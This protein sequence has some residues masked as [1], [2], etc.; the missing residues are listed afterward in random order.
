MQLDITKIIDE[1]LRSL[2]NKT[3]KKKPSKQMSFF[4]QRNS[5]LDF[6]IVFFQIQSYTL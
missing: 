4:L 5:S 6:M 3:C 1:S 2:H